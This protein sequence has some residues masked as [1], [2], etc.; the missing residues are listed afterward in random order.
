MQLNIINCVNG[1]FDILNM[2][3][4]TFMH[5]L[6]NLH[7]ICTKTTDDSS[8]ES[9]LEKSNVNYGENLIC[10]NYT[11]VCGN[12]NDDLDDLD[13]FDDCHLHGNKIINVG[14]I[15]NNANDAIIFKFKK[16]Y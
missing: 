11:P 4:I 2:H 5:L 7:K 14:N 16:N 6:L 13:N 10:E 9:T 3:I 8:N 15:V 12:C 1:L